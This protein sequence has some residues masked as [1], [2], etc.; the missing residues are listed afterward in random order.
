[1]GTIQGANP[2]KE[3]EYQEED[4]KAMYVSPSWHGES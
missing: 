2:L 3:E 4:L 1:M